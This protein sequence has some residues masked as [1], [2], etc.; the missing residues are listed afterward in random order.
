MFIIAKGTSS[1]CAAW[2]LYNL[3]GPFLKKKTK[4]C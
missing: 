2:R 4:Y 3:E 1:F